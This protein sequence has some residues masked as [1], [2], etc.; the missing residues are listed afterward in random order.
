MSN[1]EWE[2]EAKLRTLLNGMSSEEASDS[3]I[4]NWLKSGDL[5]PLASMLLERQTPGQLVLTY[6]ALMIAWTR[7]SKGLSAISIER[8]CLG[9]AGRAET[10]TRIALRDRSYS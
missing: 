4:I 5:R 10:T 3:T 7:M 9:K 1:R 8:R 6:L 2:F